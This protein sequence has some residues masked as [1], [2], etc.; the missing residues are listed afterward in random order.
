MRSSTPLS[1]FQTSRLHGILDRSF[2]ARKTTMVSRCSTVFLRM[3]S[4]LLDRTSTS[5]VVTFASDH[6]SDFY[7]DGVRID[8]FGQ[9]EQHVFQ[10]RTQVVQ[11]GRTP[12]SHQDVLLCFRSKAWRSH[13][14]CTWTATRKPTPSLLPPLIYRHPPLVAMVINVIMEFFSKT[15]TKASQK[16]DNLQQK[17]QEVATQN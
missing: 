9:E 13:T 6:P 10:V 2:Q 14:S 16:V 12:G 4:F 17:P 8:L 5:T 11:Q 3:A 1:N 7:S 15:M